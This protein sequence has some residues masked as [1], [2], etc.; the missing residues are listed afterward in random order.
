[1]LLFALFDLLGSNILISNADLLEVWRK[2]RSFCEKQNAIY[3][4]ISDKIGGS[5]LEE[6]RS[7]LKDKTEVVVDITEYE[8]PISHIAR[9]CPNSTLQKKKKFQDPAQAF[10]EFSILFQ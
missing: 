5:V 10:P 7:Y 6:N 2:Q 9:N 3:T 4:F 8:M 1:M